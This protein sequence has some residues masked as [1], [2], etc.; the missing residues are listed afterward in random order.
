VVSRA[1]KRLGYRLSGSLTNFLWSVRWIGLLSACVPPQGTRSDSKEVWEH[2][3]KS[4]CPSRTPMAQADLNG[5]AHEDPDRGRSP[6][7]ATAFWPPQARS[8]W[9]P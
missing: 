7:G 8:G 5:G 4:E 1:A 6:Q 2:G 3:T 9:R